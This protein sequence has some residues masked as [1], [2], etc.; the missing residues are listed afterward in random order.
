MTTQSNTANNRKPVHLAPLDNLPA[1]ILAP[2]TDAIYNCH[3][4]LTKVPVDAIKP[5][6]EALSRPGDLVV[7]MFAGSGMTGLAAAVLGRNAALSDIA[8][9][10][11][12]I[13]CGYLTQ[14]ERSATRE[15]AKAVIS[16]AKA[17]IGDLYLTR[18]ESDGAEVEVIRTIWSF[19]YSCPNCEAELVYFEVL[20]KDGRP[21]DACP[22]CMQKFVRRSWPRMKDKPVRV[23]VDGEA[24][25]QVEQHIRP[26]DIEKVVRALHDSRHAQVPS[27]LIA[28]DREMYGRSGLGRAGISE[29]KQFFSPRNALALL[30]LWNAINNHQDE[31][32][33]QKLRFAFTGCLARASRRYQWGPKRPL[34]AQ[35]QTYY[36]APVYF[37]WNVFDL[38]ARKVEAVLRSDDLLFNS[39]P[40]F[41]SNLSHRATYKIASADHLAHLEHESVDF[42][43]TD[44]PFGSN[45]FY[46]DMNLFHEAWLGRSTDDGTE[47]VIHTTG[48]K[49]KES[50]ARYEQTLCGAF[51]E[52]YRVLK[53]GRFMSVVFGNSSGAVWAL[54]Q[55]AL[56][57]A[58]FTEPLHIAILD[59]GQRS[60]KGLNSGSEGVVTVDLVL[61]VMKPLTKLPHR[62]AVASDGVPLVQILGDAAK[63]LKTNESRNPSY[64]Y[65]AAVREAIRIGHPLDNF[66][67]S[68]VLLGLRQLGISLDSKKGLLDKP[69]T[70][71]IL[72]QHRE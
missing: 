13:G 11:Q 24:G 50:A 19:V 58:G 62:P 68:D 67:Y 30:E 34:N 18:R 41:A 72:E 1:I 29:T 26:W 4:Y 66:H 2:R 53:P 7:D 40:L 48:R 36:V 70:A 25:K 64:V 35:N 42:V 52:A 61:T 16:S 14:V 47:A 63:T 23:V 20:D 56:R 55:R 15:A 33:R 6:I 37:E 57:D 31:A 60:V 59:K 3:A 65:A 46:S 32:I 5:F 51:A 21:V 27:L 69:L 45:I 43:F 39:T 9:L 38:F 17:A 12:H 54:V 49:K 28:R 22:K 10:G 44:P 8:V 71:E